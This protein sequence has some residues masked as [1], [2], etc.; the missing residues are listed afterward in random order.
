VSF[1]HLIGALQL[2]RSAKADVYLDEGIV[3]RTASIGLPSDARS[4]HHL[5]S[6]YDEALSGVRADWNVRILVVRTPVRTALDRGRA[7]GTAPTPNG[8]PHWFAGDDQHLRRLDEVLGQ[9]VAVATA[10]GVPTLSVDGTRSPAENVE[11]VV[12]WLSHAG[13]IEPGPAT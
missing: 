6:L 8:L 5:L 10:V 7:R 4:L 9:I 12:A 3:Q 11:E 1:L 2:A 13:A